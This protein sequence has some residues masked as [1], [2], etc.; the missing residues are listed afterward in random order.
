MM[1]WLWCARLPMSTVECAEEKACLWRDWSH[2]NEPSRRLS[3]LPVHTAADQQLA[4]SYGRQ[5]DVHP[6]AKSSIQCCTYVHFCMCFL[7]LLVHRRCWLADLWCQKTRIT[8]LSGGVICVI[9]GLASW[10]TCDRQMGGQTAIV[11]LLQQFCDGTVGG[12]ESMR[13]LA[14]PVS[15]AMAV[16]IHSHSLLVIEFAFTTSTLSSLSQPLAFHTFM[17]NWFT[18]VS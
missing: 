2:D 12:N 7:F 17:R 18:E 8:V 4:D 13:Q 16:S 1:Y 11:N 5:T 6:A 3:Q 9:L 14:D 10:W 15:P